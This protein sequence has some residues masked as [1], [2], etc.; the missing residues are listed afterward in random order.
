[1]TTTSQ[2]PP[3]STAEGL[4]TGQ[5]RHFLRKV[6]ALAKPFWY[7]EDK[8]WA[9]G[10]LLAVIALSLGGVYLSVWFNHW[11]NSFYTALQDKDAAG[12][13]LQIGYFCPVAAVAILSAV[14]R[15]YLRNI[16][17]LRWRRW[18]THVY[19]ERWLNQRAYYLLEVRGGMAQGQG[20]DNPDQRIAEDI[21]R[22]TTLTLQLGLGLLSSVVSLCSFTLILWNLS[23]A[24][25]FTLAGYDI[26]IPGYMVWVALLYAAIGTWIA[27]RLGRRLVPLNFEQ[28][29]READMRFA[30]VRV[31]EHAESIALY[32]GEDVERGAL[33][34]HFQK[35]W[36]NTWQVMRTQKRLIG[37]TAGYSQVASVFPMIVA[38]PRYFNGSL[39]LGGLMQI[40]SAF[41]HVQDAMSWFIDA[42]ASLAQWRSVVDRLT[43]FTDRLDALEQEAQARSVQQDEQAR[44]VQQAASA[45]VVSVSPASIM[46]SQAAA[47]KAADTGGCGA[48]CGCVDS[49]E[50][51]CS[52]GCGACDSS[53]D[54]NSGSESDADTN[55]G[56]GV[57]CSCMASD[58][59]TPE[60]IA[61]A[62]TAAGLQVRNLQIALPDGQTVLQLAQGQ[63]AAGQHT[64]ISAPSGYGKSLLLRVMSGIWPWWQGNL[65]LPGA[66]MFLP[67]RPY[68]PLGSLRQALAY[69]AVTSRYSDADYL[70]V[71]QQCRLSQYQ[72]RLDEVQGWSHS[73]SPGEQQRLAIARALLQQPQ[74]LVLDEATSA[75]DEDT[76]HHLYSL[77]RQQ[78]PDTTLIS[79]AHRPTVAAFH[80]Q[81]WQLGAMSS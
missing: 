55:S 25:E 39:A 41:G 1:M 37:F 80:Q 24:L 42:Y 52:G 22:F 54:G 30:L 9:R 58:E 79:V 34:Q 51:C 53:G 5:H 26:V 4:H 11:Y 63:V 73:L 19:F 60:S 67:Q 13:W 46:A 8:W 57:G 44:S 2:Q 72:S 59:D 23:G 61:V 78:L 17:E 48:G 21:D 12:F 35:I 15:Y 32:G 3:A 29:R 70:Q 14:Y 47:V 38:A 45:A 28:Q 6:W 31:R 68:I 65:S 77:L 36:D 69:P 76:E 40:N 71:L 27:H 75:L 10:L 7:S 56:C 33:R 49:E 64:L 18:L 16:L 74:W 81:H 43:S 50:T 62:D 66:M 20:T